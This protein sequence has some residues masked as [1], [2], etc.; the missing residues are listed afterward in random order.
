MITVRFQEVFIP[1]ENN[2]TYIVS[3]SNENSYLYNYYT[4]YTWPRY[5]RNLSHAMKRQSNLASVQRNL[6]L[7][8][9]PAEFAFLLVYF[10]ATI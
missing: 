2:L 10:H 6:N 5:L 3:K 4:F 7:E 8:E 9:I 1:K